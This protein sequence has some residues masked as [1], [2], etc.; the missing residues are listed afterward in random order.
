VEAALVA[1]LVAGG[2]PAAAAIAGVLAF[3]LLT[4]WLPTSPGWLAFHGLRRR[5]AI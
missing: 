3:R 5:G 4:F 1:G 2:V